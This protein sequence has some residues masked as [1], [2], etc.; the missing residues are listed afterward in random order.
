MTLPLAPLGIYHC[1]LSDP[2][3]RPELGMR[4]APAGVVKGSGAMD[5]TGSQSASNGRRY[6]SEFQR[7]PAGGNSGGNYCSKTTTKS[8]IVNGLGKSSIPPLATIPRFSPLY[9]RTPHCADMP[10]TY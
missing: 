8:F 1:D 3:V 7:S 5:L 10:I 2:V 4:C 9:C 6:D